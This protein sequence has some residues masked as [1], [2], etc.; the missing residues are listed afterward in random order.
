M[1]KRQAADLGPGDT[2][3]PGR[4]AAIGLGELEAHGNNLVLPACCVSD[5][6]DHMESPWPI[7][8][9]CKAERRRQ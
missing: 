6:S 9:P 1:N 8:G 4:G 2:S 7:V 5:G 3:G